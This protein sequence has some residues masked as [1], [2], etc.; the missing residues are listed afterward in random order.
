MQRRDAIVNRVQTLLH[1]KPVGVLQVSLQRQRLCVRSREAQRAEKTLDGA[2]ARGDRGA[3]RPLSG[4][5]CRR[6]C[7]DAR[8]PSGRRS[9]GDRSRDREPVTPRPSRTGPAPTM[10]SF[11]WTSTRSPVCLSALLGDVQHPPVR[12]YSIGDESRCGSPG[13][14]RARPARCRRRARRARRSRTRTRARAA[15]PP[16]RLRLSSISPAVTES[17]GRFST[18]CAFEGRC[19]HS[20][21]VEQI[22]RDSSRAN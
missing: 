3:S 11:V 17:P 21:G 9:S 13:L 10:S 4:D 22:G 18:R 5:T 15:A 12:R 20:C 7:A 16:S 2:D 19:G 14:R 1:L 6:A 8:R